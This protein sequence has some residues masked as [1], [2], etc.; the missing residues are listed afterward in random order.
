MLAVNL[1]VHQAEEDA[2][3][4]DTDGGALRG[5]DVSNPEAYYH[6]RQFGEL[7]LQGR[8]HEAMAE[9]EVAV[10]L[11]PLDPANHFTMGSYKG[12]IGAKQGNAALVREGLEA[13]WVAAELDKNWVLP[14]AEIGFILL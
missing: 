2:L 5:W 7:Q 10:K 1:G 13:C 12:G 4:R 6:Y 8:I 11:D 9:L 3:I 14:W